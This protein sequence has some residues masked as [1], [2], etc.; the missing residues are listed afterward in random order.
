M[1]AA[2]GTGRVGGPPPQ[3]WAPRARRQGARAPRRALRPRCCP[4]GA[5]P[6]GRRTPPCAP[7]SRR[8]CRP[9][10]PRSARA[11]CSPG[12][13]VTFD[14]RATGPRARST[15]SHWRT[16]ACMQMYARAFDVAL[17]GGGGAGRPPTTSTPERALARRRRGSLSPLVHAQRSTTRVGSLATTYGVRAD[18]QPHRARSP[19][20]SRSASSTPSAATLS[21]ARSASLAPRR[22]HRGGRLPPGRDALAAD[23]VPSL[24]VRAAVGVD[25][26]EAHA[27]RLR[28][29]VRPRPARHAHARAELHLH[30]LRSRAARHRAAPRAGRRPHRRAH[31]GGGAPAR[32]GL[33]RRRDGRGLGGHADA[34]PRRAPPRDRPRSRPLLPLDGPPRPRHRA[35]RAYGVRLVL[36]PRIGY[37]QQHSATVRLDVRPADGARHRDL[38]A[39]GTLRFTHGAAPLAS[40]IDPTSPSSPGMAPSLPT[41]WG[42]SPP[43][44]SR[45]AR[46]STFRSSVASPSPPART[47]PSRTAWSTR[48]PPAA[49]TT[50][51]SPRA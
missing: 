15:R 40:P 32:P 18:T 21:A 20:S 2:H 17:S 29:S 4:F 28:Y 34:L 8:A 47:S 7:P 19:S 6:S 27:G 45:P 1:H 14:A 42:S 11:P 37:G 30:P 48:P 44:P 10:S 43:R 23:S 12:G 41:H 3:R 31:R 35:L 49:P 39:H 16:C 25:T 22:A 33:V 51:R 13:S 9:A 50:W 36:G 38:V 26:H 46:A 24:H 5:P